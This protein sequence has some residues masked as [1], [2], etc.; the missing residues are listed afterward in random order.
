MRQINTYISE[1]YMGNG[2]TPSITEIAKAFGIALRTACC[3][4]VGMDREKIRSCQDGEIRISRISPP[5]FCH[6]P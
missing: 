6:L 5:V 2:R 4:L 3:Y 1:F